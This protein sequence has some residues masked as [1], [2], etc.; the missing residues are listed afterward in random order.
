MIAMPI[1]V[2][3]RQVM[4][5]LVTI[6]AG[7]TVRQ[8]LDRMIQT[9]VWSLLAERQGVPVGVITDHD[10]LQRCVAKGFDANRIKVEE[11]MSSLLITI[12]SDKRAGVALE[13]M[14]EMNVGRLYVIETGKV[15][16]RVTQRGLSANLLDV[17]LTLS[18]VTPQL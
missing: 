3:V 2:M 16:G 7:Q 15:I 5:P 8:A 11:I 9:H 18:R 17:M 13:K 1:S 4:D 6:G 14:V 10:I 12:E